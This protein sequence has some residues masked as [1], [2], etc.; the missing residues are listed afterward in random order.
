VERER[1]RVVVHAHVLRMVNSDLLPQELET[2]LFSNFVLTSSNLAR[3][4]KLVV[5]H[6]KNF[7]NWHVLTVLSILR[8]CYHLFSKYSASY[9]NWEGECGLWFEEY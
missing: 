4:K 8:K 3:A 2:A 9:K 1:D 7:S 5:Y 6:Y